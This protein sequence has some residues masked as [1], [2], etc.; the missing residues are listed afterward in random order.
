MAIVE[1]PSLTALRDPLPA[2]RDTAID[3][4][5]AVCVAGVVLLHAIMVGVT[6]VDGS[7][8]FANASEGSWWICLLYTSDAAD[9]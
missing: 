8:V 4:L 9:E 6:V 7:P 1:A 5:R 2:G 3:F